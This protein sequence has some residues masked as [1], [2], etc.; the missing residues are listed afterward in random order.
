MLDQT[1]TV[2]L[3]EPLLHRLQ[4]VA[5]L[6]YRSVDDI[7]VSAVDT[8]LYTSPHL[9]PELADEIAAMALFKD[10]ALLAAAESSITPAQQRR[11]GQLTQASKERTL[12]PPESAELDHLIDLYDKAVLRRGHALALLAQR[13]YQLSDQN[14]LP[15]DSGGEQF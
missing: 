1:I 4:R 14:E 3:P 11:L 2:K 10:D 5:Q 13:G 12:D 8:T 7:I 6:T 9:P 15:T